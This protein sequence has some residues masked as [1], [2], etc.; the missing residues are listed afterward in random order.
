MSAFRPHEG[1]LHQGEALVDHNLIFNPP[2]LNPTLSWT[3]R[4]RSIAGIGFV[5]R[6]RPDIR[7][8]SLLPLSSPTKWPMGDGVL[9]TCI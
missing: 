9:D 8:K 3:L 1:L 4:G 5:V 7:G 2:A 6:L